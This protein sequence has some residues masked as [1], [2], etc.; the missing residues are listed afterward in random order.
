M[1]ATR[2]GDSDYEDGCEG[3]SCNDEYGHHSSTN[4]YKYSVHL[5]PRED[6]TYPTRKGKQILVMFGL[7]MTCCANP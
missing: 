4:I 5:L 2:S 7:D 6:V 3:E 1:D